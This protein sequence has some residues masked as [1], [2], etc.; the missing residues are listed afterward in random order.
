MMMT[1]PPICT[2]SVF[3]MVPTL[4]AAFVIFCTVSCYPVFAADR[5]VLQLRW[6]N[7][8]QFAGYYAAKWQGFYE[9][10]GIDVEIKPGLTRNKKI[11]SAIQE[12]AEGRAQFGI[13][14]ADIIKGIDEGYPLVLVA[15]IFQHSAAALYTRKDT[16]INTPADF[17]KLKVARRVGDLI[18]IE[19]QA[20]LKAEG[21]D[22]KE[23]MPYRHKPGIDHLMSGEVDVMPGY[24]IN[25][26]FTAST[27]G[28]SIKEFRP[29][30]YGV[31][32]YGDSIFTSQKIVKDN[33]ELINRF[34]AASIKGWEYALEHPVELVLRISEELPRVRPLKN[35]VK[36]NTYQS[37]AIRRLIPYPEVEIGHINPDRWYRMYTYLNELGLVSQPLSLEECIYNPERLEQLQN[38]RRDQ[39]LPWALAVICL[40][41]C[42]FVAWL[43]LL[44]KTVS[45]K[46]SEL[47]LLNEQ[48]LKS[49]AK[50]RN[51]VDMAQEGIWV[52]DKD[53]NTR[54]V[55]PSMA[56]ML[57]YSPEEM[58]DRPLFSFMDSAGIALASQ[59]IE[60]RKEGVTETHDFEFLKKDGTRIYV[61]MVTAPILNSEGE[62][63]GAIAGVIDITHRME[64][65]RTLK[66]SEKRFDL[67]MRFTNDGLY[68]WDLI[69]DDIYFSPG[70]KKMLGYEP[71]ELEDTF[72]RWEQLTHPA[73]V[74]AA[75]KMLEEVISGDR[76][77]FELEFQMKHKNGSWVD[78]FSRGN[79]VF[80]DNQKARRLVGTHVDITERKKYENELKVMTAA[81]DNSLNGF[82]IVSG[83]SSFLYVN[84][85]YVKMWGYESAEEIIGT[86]PADHCVDPEMP[87]EIIR[88]LQER[89]EY[90]FELEAKRKDGS[91]FDVLMYA[92]LAHDEHGNEIFP[93][94]CIDISERKKA[95]REK[96]LL[97]RQLHQAQKMESIG[98]LAGG[99][100]HDFNNILASVLGFTELAIED[101]PKNSEQ[102]GNLQEVY[103]A[104]LRATELVKRILAFAR[105]TDETPQPVKPRIIVNEVLKLLRPSLPTTIQ[106]DHEIT[107]T[108]TIEANATQLHQV[109]L[110]ICTNAAHAM[111]ERDGVLTLRLRDTTLNKKCSWTDM[112]LSYGNY[113][114]LTITDN[115]VGISPEIMDMIFD[116]YF[117]T[118][119]V[120]E[121]TGMGLAMVKGIVET[122]K[123][124]I[125]VQS[126]PN[127]GT[128]F[129]ILFPTT[130]DGGRLEP[131]LISD[132]AKGSEHIL[133]VDDEPPLARLGAR[134]LESLGYQVTSRTSSYEALE[135]FK[136]KPDYFDLVITDMTMPHMTGDELACEVK[137]VRPDMPVVV[138]TGY[139]TKISEEQA[140]QIGINAFTYKPLSKVDLATIVRKVLD[141][142]S[143][144]S[145]TGE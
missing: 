114:E 78:I 144:G 36:F 50:Y 139:S 39:V 60:R 138:C 143:D 77:R 102:M 62:Y 76:D 14:G 34:K 111:R 10:V 5:V 122:Y 90:E 66:E 89:G 45:A 37:E 104:G 118:K 29:I 79:V 133:F 75:W 113:V 130:K 47:R 41:L 71:D 84:K 69:T 25:I 137:K 72:S 109:I 131:Y 49:E 56:Q 53:S 96:D 85:A 38:E 105:Q 35:T 117:T 135:L 68:D 142:V 3:R 52:I 107:S 9:E 127:V 58:Q 97:E 28:V 126:E 64:T 40:T 20:M 44:K 65:E 106:I 1:I 88:V 134:L 93:T 19:F 136:E 17:L 54:F 99:I 116:P 83:D 51:L 31:D 16:V 123:G 87:R 132:P 86:S 43:Y 32:F 21:V 91:R 103:G 7:Q 92:R 73:G 15:P 26:P 82:D 128:T 124:K 70:W 48:L 115:G 18:D 140:A 119:E 121:G 59:K 27:K 13:G 80:D 125:Q 141:A 46:T 74:E 2:R 55:N 94:T 42:I 100:A 30:A 112:G 101:A 110:N 98:N 8:F 33:P 11:V 22:P 108:A 6:D 67:A 129:T 95:Q 61:T 23:V 120:G 81:I 4:A 145:G 24:S 57:G 12:V 63:D